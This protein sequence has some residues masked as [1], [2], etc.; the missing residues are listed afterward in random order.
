MFGFASD[1]VFVKQQ[2]KYQKIVSAV[3][4]RA[5]DFPVATM[6]LWVK[7][8]SSTDH[9]EILIQVRKQACQIKPSTKTSYKRVRM[10]S[11]RL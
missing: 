2:Q 8:V 5:F 6:F 1:F 11:F 4:S 9:P 3:H 10:I 7:L